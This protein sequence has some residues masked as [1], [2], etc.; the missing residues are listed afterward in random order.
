MTTLCDPTELRRVTSSL[1]HYLDSKMR[2]VPEDCLSEVWAMAHPQVEGLERAS[3]ISLFA[4]EGDGCPALDGEVLD[5]RTR[6]HRRDTSSDSFIWRLDYDEES[7]KLILALG[8]DD[9]EIWVHTT[10]EFLYLFSYGDYFYRFPRSLGF[11]REGYHLAER[12]CFSL[13]P[14]SADD[15][16]LSSISCATSCDNTYIYATGDFRGG[17]SDFLVEIDVERDIGR[18]RVIQSGN[19]YP[20]SATVLDGRSTLFW[21]N[22]SHPRN[23]YK[24]TRG[25]GGPGSKDRCT[26]FL[27]HHGVKFTTLTVSKQVGWF[28]SLVPVRFW[29]VDLIT[30]TILAVFQSAGW[31]HDLYARPDGG[32]WAVLWTHSKELLVEV[33]KPVLEPR[34]HKPIMMRRMVPT[35][36]QS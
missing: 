18:Y 9:D 11:I 8:P 10:E 1:L 29:Q 14:W 5:L 22:G 30:E 6:T 24:W 35:I 19:F 36:T 3:R 23:A 12:P 7:L 21:L 33:W 34:P 27:Q 17:E 13:R 25:R 32:L 20:P 2:G 15:K 28:E 4:Q 31:S 16:R 26:P